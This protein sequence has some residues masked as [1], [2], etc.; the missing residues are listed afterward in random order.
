MRNRYVSD[1]IMTDVKIAIRFTSNYGEHPDDFYDPLALP[2]IE[3]ITIKDVTGEN[4]KIFMTH[5]LSQ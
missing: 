3:K 1:V 2:I 5:L 4:V